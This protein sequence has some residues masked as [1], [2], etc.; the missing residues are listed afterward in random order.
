LNVPAAEVAESLIQ[1]AVADAA[2]LTQVS[3]PSAEA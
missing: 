1:S 3:G 2:L